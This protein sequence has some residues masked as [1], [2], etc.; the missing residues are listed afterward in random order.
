VEPRI[1][2]RISWNEHGAAIGQMQEGADNLLLCTTTNDKL[3][4]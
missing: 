1:P 3:M 2:R 4:D